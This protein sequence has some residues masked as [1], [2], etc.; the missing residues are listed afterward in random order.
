MAPVLVRGAGWAP[1]L[2]LRAPAARTRAELGYVR[3]M[4]LNTVRLEGKLIDDDFFD[5]A[6]EL[7][8]L[9]MPGWW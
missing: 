6:D 5:A 2:F 8:V 9:T 3:A 4:G 7:G 1:D